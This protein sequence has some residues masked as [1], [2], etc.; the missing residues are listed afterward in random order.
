MNAATIITLI[1][2]CVAAFFAIKTLKKNGGHTC[3]Q[4]KD[5]HSCPYSEEGKKCD[6]EKH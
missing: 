1:I 6:R 2:I 3:S 4:C 5:C